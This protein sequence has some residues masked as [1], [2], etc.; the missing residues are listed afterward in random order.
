M[1]STAALNPTTLFLASRLCAALREEEPAM[2]SREALRTDSS[3]P[4]GLNAAAY[5][6]ISG[7]GCLVIPDDSDDS[8]LSWRL[9]LGMI[10]R[11]EAESDEVVFEWDGE[12]PPRVPDLKIQTVCLI[13]QLMADAAWFEANRDADSDEDDSDEDDSDDEDRIKDLMLTYGVLSEYSGCALAAA[14]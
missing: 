5:P 6:Y 9:A 14:A 4:R 7:C 1:L 3:L 13:D 11:L 2:L 8:P 10:Q 12:S